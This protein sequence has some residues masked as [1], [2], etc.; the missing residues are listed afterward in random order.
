MKRVTQQI[1]TGIRQP[2]SSLEANKANIQEISICTLIMLEQLF[3]WANKQGDSIRRNCWLVLAVDRCNVFAVCCALLI[4]RST[5]NAL[6]L[7]PHALLTANNAITD[8]LEA[9]SGG[10]D[11]E[12][13]CCL[14]ELLYALLCTRCAWIGRVRP[15]LAKDLCCPIVFRRVFLALPCLF[16]EDSFDLRLSCFKRFRKVPCHLL[17]RPRTHASMSGQDPWKC[18]KLS[19]LPMTTKSRGHTSASEM[20]CLLLTLLPAASPVEEPKMFAPYHGCSLQGVACTSF[21]PLL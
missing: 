19:S 8:L 4:F 3:S 5:L 11:W 6:L 14:D 15:R 16:S 20:L 13:I 2:D 18:R 1:S 12:T 17:F 7:V 10:E 21:C 9:I